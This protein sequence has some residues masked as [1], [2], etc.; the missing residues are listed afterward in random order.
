MDQAPIERTLRDEEVFSGPALPVPTIIH[1]SKT[2]DA[3]HLRNLLAMHPTVQVIS[4]PGDP[5]SAQPPAK[6]V[7]ID[8]SDMSDALVAWLSSRP[9]DV[10]VVFT[11]R[12]EQWTMQAF[13]F[14]ALDYLLKPISS[15]RLAQTMRRLLRLDWGTAASVRSVPRRLFVAFERGR[16]VVALDDVCAIRALG[17]YTQVW[18]ANGK[19]EVVLRSLI[20]WQ[21]SLPDGLFIRVHRTLLVNRNRIARLERGENDERVI[22]IEGLAERFPVSRRLARQVQRSMTTSTTSAA[23]EM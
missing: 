16:R 5:L 8:P 19:T 10:E 1:D 2:H 17:N 4:S 22:E 14:G 21:E 23:L 9:A 12:T 18:L 3:A 6:L 15:E 7:F 11:A 13:E 20:R